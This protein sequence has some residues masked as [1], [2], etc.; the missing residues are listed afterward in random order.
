MDERM[1]FY[2]RFEHDLISETFLSF[3]PS[4]GRSEGTRTESYAV[5]Y[6]HMFERRSLHERRTD[7]FIWTRGT[8][9][10]R[11]I[12]VVP[13]TSTAVHVACEQ[14]RYV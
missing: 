2:T 5:R 3:V 9:G 1:V 13:K 8:Y 7:I 10:R 4:A 11:N 14:A 12:R 6:G